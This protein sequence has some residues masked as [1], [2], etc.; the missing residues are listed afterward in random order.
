VSK[1]CCAFLL[2]LF[3]GCGTHQTVT[4][5]KGN[6]ELEF[7]GRMACKIKYG[8]QEKSINLTGDSVLPSDFI[9]VNGARISDFQLDH[10]SVDEKDTATESGAVSQMRLTGFNAQFGIYKKVTVRLYADHPGMISWTATYTNSSAKLLQI[11]KVVSN[12][13]ALDVAPPGTNAD[14][15]SLWTYQGIAKDWGGDYIFPMTR[16]FHQ[17]N[18][19]GIQPVSRMGGG[20]P[21]MD[22]WTREAGIAIAHLERKPRLLSFPVD[23]DE[24]GKVSICITDS[25]AY[26]LAPGES[27]S[28]IESAVFVHK[29]DFFDPL[30]TYAAVMKDRGLAMAAPAR[31]TYEPV[32]CGWGYGSDFTLDQIYRTLPKLKQLGFKWVDIDDRWFDRYG[33]WNPRKEIFPRGEAQ[34]KELVDSIHKMGLLAKVWWTPILA[35]PEA[36]PPGGKWPSHSPGMS[37]VVK[38]H[39]D[40]LVMDKAGNFPRC[41]RNMYF[42]DASLPAVQEYVRQL[43]LKFVEK[44]GFDGHKLDAFWV[45]PPSYNPS[46]PYPSAAYENVPTLIR[47]IRETSKSIKP[48][49]VTEVCNCGTPQDFYQSLY[50]DQPVIADPTSFSQVRSRVK[51]F[52]ALWGPA[53]PIFTDHVEHVATFTDPIVHVVKDDDRSADDF[54]STIGTGG[55]PGSK[56]TWPGGDPVLQL[57]PDKENIWKNWISIYEEKKLSEGQYLNMYDI[58]FDKPEGHVIKKA[59]SMYYAF[60]AKEW[61]GEVELRGLDNKS[62]RVTDYEHGKVLGTWKGPVIRFSHPFKKHLLLQCDPLN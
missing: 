30:A 11:D 16:G 23:V 41:P 52:K 25:L 32:W 2:V 62:Y 6:L 48:Y 59:G 3:T 14:S 57:T 35:Q 10:N 49:S 55:V 29:G 20:I 50:I 44:W 19:T 42:L 12:Y 45:E 36:P 15:S 61:E 46:T 51:A 43:T 37:D 31:E 7:D 58:A 26:P 38:N 13:F 33:D 34:M 47:I 22:Y 5:R 17:Q 27:F 54:G 18:Y 4:F 40:W 8:T 60:Y 21:L 1:F 28:T 56:F 53:S 39:P 9:V 24:N